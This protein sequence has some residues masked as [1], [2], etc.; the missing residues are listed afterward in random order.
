MSLAVRHSVSSASNTAPPS[1]AEAN[2]LRDEIYHVLH[3][4]QMFAG[5]GTGA[6]SATPATRRRR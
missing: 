3:E 5:D 2:A 6:V 1:H 4:G